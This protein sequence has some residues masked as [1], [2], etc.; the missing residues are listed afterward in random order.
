LS[1]GTGIPSSWR[2]RMY[3]SIVA[4]KKGTTTLASAAFGY[5]W[6]FSGIYY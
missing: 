5:G 2:D 3:P 1:S 4:A 6:F